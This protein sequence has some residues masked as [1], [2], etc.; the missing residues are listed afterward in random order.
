MTG[1]APRPR[2]LRDD[3]ARF[4]RGEG[5][6]FGALALRLFRQQV[7]RN[8]QYRAIVGASVVRSWEEIP[9]VPVALWRD[10]PLVSFP[11]KES[12]LVFRTSGTTGRRGAVH[13]LDTELYDLGARRFAEQVVGPIPTAGVS[14]VP[15]AED[16]SLGHMCRTFSPELVSRFRGR[17]GV[18]CAGA[19]SDLQRFS[20]RTEP[21][22]LPGTALALAELVTRME[23]PIPLAAGSIVMVTGGFKGKVAQ[24]S[25]T[26]LRAELVRLFPGAAVVE[27]DNSAKQW[28]VSR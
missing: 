17:T 22:F 23:A 7:E 26:T 11:L 27:E 28:K 1:P 25:A 3:I 2:A 13:R 6:D 8:P 14:L 24:V 4:V 5:G 21:V 18:D 9:C 10:L 12:A 20:Q 16:S 15:D 19:L